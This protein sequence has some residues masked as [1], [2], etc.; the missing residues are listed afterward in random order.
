MRNTIIVIILVIIILG[1]AYAAY[2]FGVE[3]RQEVDTVIIEEPVEENRPLTEEEQLE[4]LEEM[5]PD[6][7]TDTPE[8]RQRD[9]DILDQLMNQ[10]E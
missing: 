6:N 4:I 10:Q 1:V 9:I 8:E 5:E 7:P 3:L 2:Y